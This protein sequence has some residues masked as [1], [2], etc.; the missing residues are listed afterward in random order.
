MVSISIFILSKDDFE[1]DAYLLVIRIRSVVH[2]F[3]KDLRKLGNIRTI[4]KLYKF[5]A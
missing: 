2:F 3:F 4:S 1:I 5:I